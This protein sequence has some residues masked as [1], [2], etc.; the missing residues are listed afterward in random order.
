MI[1]YVVMHY[2]LQQSNSRFLY[3]CLIA[4]VTGIVQLFV[5]PRTPHQLIAVLGWYGLL[6]FILP[7]SYILI[8]RIAGRAALPSGKTR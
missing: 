6:L 5:L 4:V 8:S 7:F 1:F 2:F 3:Y